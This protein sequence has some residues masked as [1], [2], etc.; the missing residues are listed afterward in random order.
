[1]N[2]FLKPLLTKCNLCRYGS[3][4]PAGTIAALRGAIT[5]AKHAKPWLAQN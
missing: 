3:A 1:M 2:W 5:G 4:D